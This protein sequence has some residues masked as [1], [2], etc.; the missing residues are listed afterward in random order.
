ME[1][2]TI[3]QQSGWILKGD[4]R[5]RYQSAYHILV[6]SNAE[7]LANDDGDI[8]DSGKTFFIRNSTVQDSCFLKM[9]YYSG[10]EPHNLHVV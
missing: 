5:N 9:S 7:K 10:M 3:R 6:A 2:R 1:K 4:D 8:W